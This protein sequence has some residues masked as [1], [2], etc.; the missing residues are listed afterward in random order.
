MPY[1]D[2]DRKN[3]YMKNYYS[4]RRMLLNHLAIR[5]KE[6]ENV[7]LNKYIVKYH[8]NF[9]S[10]ISTYKLFFDFFLKHK[11]KQKAST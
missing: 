6:L 1:V 11:R 9:K 3:I 7:C 8:K 4:T 10:K 5:V 2:R